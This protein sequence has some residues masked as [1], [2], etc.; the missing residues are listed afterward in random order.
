[1]ADSLASK[2]PLA[3]TS[4]KASA[5]ASGG[6][7]AHNLKRRSELIDLLFGPPTKS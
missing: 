7:G 6:G 1:L 4:P 2:H 5:A 3:P